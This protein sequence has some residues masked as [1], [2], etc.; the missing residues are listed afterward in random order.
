M[1][2]GASVVTDWFYRHRETNEGTASEHQGKTEEQ[3]GA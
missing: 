2:F 3:Q 1:G